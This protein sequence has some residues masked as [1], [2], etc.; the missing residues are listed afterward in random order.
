MLRLDLRER[1]RKRSVIQIK[2]RR[3]QMIAMNPSSA[4]IQIRP[5]QRIVFVSHSDFAF[6]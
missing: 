4:P 1:N 6:C 3:A 5:Q 2:S